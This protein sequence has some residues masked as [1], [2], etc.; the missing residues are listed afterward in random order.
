MSISLLA[1]PCQ[2]S[3][4]TTPDDSLNVYSGAN[5][6]TKSMTIIANSQT[7]GAIP[8]VALKD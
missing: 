3:F 6:A 5:R 2:S 1:H 8:I 4:D 7:L